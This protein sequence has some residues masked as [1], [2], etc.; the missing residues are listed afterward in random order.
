MKKVLLFLS[1]LL[2]S[3][4]ISEKAAKWQEVK[5]GT[6]LEVIGCDG[7]I[8]RMYYSDGAI[9]GGPNYGYRFIDRK[10]GKV[11]EVST[12]VIITYGE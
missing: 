7:S 9:Q 3:S 4:C 10:T 2:F 12:N 8:I 5:S 6:K 1:I 11:V